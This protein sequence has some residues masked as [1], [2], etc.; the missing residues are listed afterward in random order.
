MS[1][2]VPEQAPGPSAAASRAPAGSVL[3][4][5]GVSKSYVRSDRGELQ[6]AI[7]DVSFA[8]PKGQFWCLLGLSG[9]GKTTILNLAAGFLSP[10]HGTVRVGD[11]V[12]SKPGPDRA[13]VFQDDALLPWLQVR[14]NVELVLRLQRVPAAERRRRIE[15]Y[16]EMVGLADAIEKYPHQLSGG[17]Q[18]RVSIARAL[19]LEPVILLMD[20]PFASLDAHTR[21]QMQ[22][23]LIRIWEE[24]SKTVLFVTHSVDEALYLADRILIIG[25]RPGTVVRAIDVHLRRPRDRTSQDFNEIE[26]HVLEVLEDEMEAINQ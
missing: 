21:M 5:D 17:M 25:Q 24:T 12:V 15:H 2:P 14:G 3:Q 20:E 11:T 18:Q 23:E 1:S 6:Y 7:Q 16:L 13:M 9:S 8:Q 26:R 22:R 19:A 4:F 10:T